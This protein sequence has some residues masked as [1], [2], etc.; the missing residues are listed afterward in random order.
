MKTSIITL[1][2]FILTAIHTTC[3]STPL[4]SNDVSNSCNPSTHEKLDYFLKIADSLRQNLNVP[5]V[6]IAIV[7]N[8]D[9]LYA[10]GL[11]YSN[12]EAGVFVNKNTLFSIGSCTKSFTGVLTAKLVEKDLLNWRTPLKTY[13]PDLKLKEQYI[14]KHA[15]LIDALSHSTG[16]ANN[17]QAWKY[18][19]ISRDDMF[20]NMVNQEFASSFRSNYI[21][22]NMMFAVGGLAAERVTGK[23]WE[24]LIKSEIFE[25]LDMK[26]S[27]AKFNEFITHHNKS[28]G[29]KKD[30]LTPVPA[31]DLTMIAPA[32]AICSTP[33]DMAKWL[34]VFVNNGSYNGT[35]LLKLESYDYITKPHRKVS[36]RN[37][38][39]IWYYY[40][41]IGGYS[42]NGKRSIGH[43]GAI[44]GQNS[45]M[46][47]K[48]DD[49][50]AIMI[51]TNQI[52][53]YKELLVEYAE[54]WFLE[55]T[56]TRQYDRE[57]GLESIT[58]SYIVEGMLD[59][60]QEKE[61]I[62][63][64]EKLNSKKLGISLEDNMNALGYYYLKNNKLNSAIFILKLNSK[65][66]PTST[67][68]FNSLGEAHYLS[69]NYE[70]ALQA[71]QTSLK[72]DSNNKSSEDYI[73]KIKKQLKN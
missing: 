20:K 72:L 61:V 30:G 22:N 67:N 45:R 50:F 14:E 63:Y 25:P 57:Y 60:G 64:F 7:Y 47:M 55:G 19:D 49:G 69:K 8:N 38:D 15:T 48:P 11:G 66:F 71:F 9:I 6:G 41:G 27:V 52:S 33:Q 21:Y 44:D 35:T 53:E 34:S 4:N 5:G 31:V 36:I 42:K 56:L 51:M 18:R 17:T 59:R 10:G 70:L 13:M 24:D 68:A 28:I 58:H 16:L 73:T 26:N 3:F 40:A 43:N 46:V 2:L 65:K 39:E 62:D 54:E 1:A 37:G 23:S 29:Y 12:R 32:G